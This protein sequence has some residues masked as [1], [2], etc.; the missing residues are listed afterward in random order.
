AAITIFIFRI[1]LKEKIRP[2]KVPFYPVIPI[3]F[4][5]ISGWFIFKVI[6]IDHGN[7]HSWIHNPIIAGILVLGIGIPFYIYFNYRNKKS[8]T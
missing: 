7:D 3:I 2:Y 8:P 1:K 5:V 4:I 6:G